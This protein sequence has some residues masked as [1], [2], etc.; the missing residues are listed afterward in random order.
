MIERLFKFI[1]RSDK[2]T[3]LVIVLFFAF[4]FFS[5]RFFITCDGPAHLYNANLLLNFFNGADPVVSSYFELNAYPVPNWIGHLILA[6]LNTFLPVEAVEKVFLFIY[7]IAFIYSFK[8]LVQSFNK[9]IGVFALLILPFAMSVFLNAGFYD[10]C[11]SFIFLFLSIGFF[12]RHHQNMSLKKGL[13]LAL[14]LILL[15]F[16][17]VTITL[18]AISFL[19]LFLVWQIF[20]EKELL[21]KEKFKLIFR[22]SISLL[23]VCLPVL[24]FIF[25]YSR[26]HTPEIKFEYLDNSSL[27]KMLFN[28]SPL[29]GHGPGE[30]FYTRI[31]LFILTFLIVFFLVK[32]YWSDKIK[33]KLKK[34]DV[35]V[36]AAIILLIFYF[37]LPD[38]DTKGGY[39]SARILYLFY[40]MIFIRV[41]LMDFPNWLKN[42]ALI[43]M[44]VT[45]YFHVNLNNGGQAKLNKWAKMTVEAGEFIRP[46]SV[47]LPINCSTHWQAVHLPK[48]LGAKKSIVLLENY[49]A[50][51]VYFPIVWKSELPIPATTSTYPVDIC[52]KYFSQFDQFKNLPDYLFFYGNFEIAMPLGFAIA[53]SASY[54]QHYNRI[55]QNDF[56]E[57]YE[58]K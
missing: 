13:M 25:F 26:L 28:I 5:Y 45:F 36:I 53:D 16:S 50:G 12:V 11:L 44:V 15:Y 1:F 48:Y 21:S 23:L 57:L 22:N 37:I 55:H 47:V 46:N 32:K 27:L 40:L 42:D 18:F 17:H 4:F 19:F 29:V 54:L 31:Y 56:C 14:F 33:F 35:F 9:D 3:F 8:Y 30:F 49:E 43:V 7:F 6:F 39:I 34:E 38:G 41:I 24:I 52:S 51:H 10:F 20:L 58:L 2:I